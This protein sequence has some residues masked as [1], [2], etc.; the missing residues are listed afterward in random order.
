MFISNGKNVFPFAAELEEREI[1]FLFVTAYGSA[2]GP[3]EEFRHHHI[4]QKP[5]RPAGMRGAPWMDMP[6]AA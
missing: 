4:L 3:P 5:L 1:P 2:R 6:I